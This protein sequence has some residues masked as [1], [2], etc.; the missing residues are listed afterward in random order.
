MSKNK[1]AKKE[2]VK[3]YTGIFNAEHYFDYLEEEEEIEK[4]LG[5]ATYSKSTN[6]KLVR[7]AKFDAFNKHMRFRN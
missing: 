4:K 3:N 6:A 5:N 1:K 7:D 2:F